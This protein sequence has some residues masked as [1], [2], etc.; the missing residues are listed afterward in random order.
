MCDRLV[1]M[2]CFIPVRLRP[3]FSAPLFLVIKQFPSFLLNFSG[4][5]FNNARDLVFVDHG[6]SS[7]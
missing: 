2:R 6:Y 1:S 3:V 7:I 4:E 5:I